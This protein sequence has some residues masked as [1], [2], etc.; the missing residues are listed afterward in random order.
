MKPT[1]TPSHSNNWVEVGVFGLGPITVDVQSIDRSPIPQS[2]QLRFLKVH[3]HRTKRLWFIWDVDE[4]EGKL[5]TDRRKR[6]ICGCVGGCS[7][8][9]NNTNGVRFFTNQAL[10]ASS[11]KY[12][13]YGSE[14]LWGGL[15]TDLGSNIKEHLQRRS[16]FLS[17]ST[18]IMT[19]S[20]KI[21]GGRGAN[22]K[23][24]SSNTGMDS[25]L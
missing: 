12:N 18:N 9:G 4:L 20:G 2:Q 25:R 14:S 1:Y 11:D 10:D 8:F 6:K 17:T 7:F 16:G 22:S 23:V 13:H 21:S 24:F 19:S 3:D 5:A 15:H